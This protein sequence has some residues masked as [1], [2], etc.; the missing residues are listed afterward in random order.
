MYVK[1]PINTY[2]FIETSVFLGFGVIQTGV[3]IVFKLKLV[4]NISL[5]H[6]HNPLI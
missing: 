1:I 5:N 3:R 2:T 6:F 4:T